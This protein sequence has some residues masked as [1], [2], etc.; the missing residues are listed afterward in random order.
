M[1]TLFPEYTTP[2][3]PSGP[4]FVDV[5]L[6]V[7]IPRMFTYKVPA[8]LQAQLQIGARVLV[9]FGKKKI[10]TG[11]V[12]KAHHT[13]PQIYEAKPVLDVLDAHPSVTALQI[14]FW[15]WMASYYCCHIGEV[16]GAALPSGLR[17]SS[18]SKLQLHPEFDR[19]ESPYPLDIRKIR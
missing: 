12:G 6:P 19:E 10:L 3:P 15:G 5:I 2:P 4:P 17:L 14:R 1:D 9:Q 11:I 13:P 16:M 7:P 8:A 18:E